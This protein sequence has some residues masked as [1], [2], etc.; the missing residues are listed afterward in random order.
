MKK[1]RSYLCGDSFFSRFAKVNSHKIRLLVLHITDSKEYVDE[2][3]RRLTSAK[4][5]PN[6]W[7]EISS[8]SAAPGAAASQGDLPHKKQHPPLA[9][10]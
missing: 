4:R 2:F 3:I 9:P 10:P 5:L 8:G 1:V 6:S 7:C